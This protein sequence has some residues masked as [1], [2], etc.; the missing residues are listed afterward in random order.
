MEKKGQGA[1]EYLLIIGGA[2][3]VAAITIALITGTTSGQK[4]TRAQTKCAILPDCA[5]CVW[6]APTDSPTPVSVSTQNGCV[7]VIKGSTTERRVPDGTSTTPTAQCTL[8]AGESF[9]LCDT[10]RTI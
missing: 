2:V 6:A 3:L 1:L 8:G 7:A 9:K 4:D 10:N 5:G